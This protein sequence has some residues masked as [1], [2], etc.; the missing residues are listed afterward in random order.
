ML[1]KH[2]PSKDP[3]VYTKPF[4]D[5]VKNEDDITKMQYADIRTWLVQDILV[6]A[7]RMS[8]ANSLE[9][10]VPFLDKEML[11]IALRIPS[12]YRVNKETTKVAL[13]GAAAK[14]LP[15]QTAAMR[16]T[17]FLTPLNDWL[18][19]D[20]Y[21]NMVKEKFEGEVAAKFFNRDYI[22][23]LLDE[24]KAGTA[25]NMK[26]IWSVYSFILWYEKYFVEN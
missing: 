25:H 13:R 26:K 4:F 20:E 10:R 21:Y 23:K 17:G 15:A 12:E 16:K 2:I 9:L 3:A 19:R 11:K 18:R 5:E 22:M 6:K 8:M 24:H 1:A 7:D 14:E